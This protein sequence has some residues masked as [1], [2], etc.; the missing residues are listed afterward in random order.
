MLT[1]KE[2]VPALQMAQAVGERS[3]G[4]FDHDSNGIVGPAS[5]MSIDTLS[6]DSDQSL[7]RSVEETT[8][9]DNIAVIE[10]TFTGELLYFPR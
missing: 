5:V 3:Y 7:Q 9:A 2:L 4:H 1:I 6:H 8:L 10:D